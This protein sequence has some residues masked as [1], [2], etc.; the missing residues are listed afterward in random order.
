MTNKT[1]IIF[2]HPKCGKDVIYLNIYVIFSGIRQ[3]TFAL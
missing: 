2:K 3:V 1:Y